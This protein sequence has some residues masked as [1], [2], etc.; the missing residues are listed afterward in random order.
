MFHVDNE[1]FHDR[2]AFQRFDRDHIVVDVL[3]Q[4][5]AGQATGALDGH[6]AGTADR[7]AAAAAVRHRAVLFPLDAVQHDEQAL[8]RAAFDFELLV[9][10][11]RIFGRIKA[12]NAEGALHHYGFALG[13]IAASAIVIAPV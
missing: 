2:E 12:Q 7:V 8:F 4:G 11:C 6:A 9:A 13:G 3:H 5:A 10:R 1:I